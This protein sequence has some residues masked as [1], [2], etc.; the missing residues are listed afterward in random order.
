MKRKILL[1]IGIITLFLFNIKPSYSVHLEHL[2]SPYSILADGNSGT[3]LAQHHA[4]HKIYPASLTKIMTA[5]VAIENTDDMNQVITLPQDIFQ[6]LYAE[7]A[8]LA[9]FEPGEQVQ[10]KDLLY[11]ILLPSGA[12]CCLAFANHISGSEE[13]FVKLMNQKAKD[14]GMKHTHFCNST[15]LHNKRHYSTVKDISILLQYA[16]KNDVFRSAFT[17]TQ[18]NA[19][20]GL[21]LYSTLFQNMQNAEITGGEIIGGK[22]GYTKQAGLCLASAAN[23]NGK[24][25]I[26]VTAKAAGTHQTKQFHILDAIYVYNQIGKD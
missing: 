19:T 15:G 12:E 17:S 14:L 5:V 24:E 11:G 16:L 22:T 9:G 21:T 3:V 13:A 23:V 6:Q 20:N 10:L 4:Q 2:Y 7:N 8:S 18:Y 1:V 25:Y 26:L